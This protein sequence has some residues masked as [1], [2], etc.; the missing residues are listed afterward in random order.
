MA[1]PRTDPPEVTRKPEASAAS[2]PAVVLSYGPGSGCVFEFKT[3]RVLVDCYSPLAAASADIGPDGLLEGF[4]AVA[5]TEL[6]PMRVRAIGTIVVTCE[7]LETLEKYFHVLVE[8]K[9]V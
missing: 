8:S 7:D 4:R 1:I 5:V 9:E 2:R 3:G 6:E